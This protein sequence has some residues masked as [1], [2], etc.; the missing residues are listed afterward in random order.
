[1]K[2]SLQEVTSYYE[3]FE[4]SKLQ[5]LVHS[6]FKY[7]VRYSNL[8]AEWWL[9]DEEKRKEMDP[10]RTFAHNAFISSC[11]ALARNMQ[12]DKED[13]TWRV[14]MGEDRKDIGDFAILLVA[15]MGIKAR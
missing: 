14:K 8:R 13:V 15:V 10:E 3:I 7:A 2:I 5:P 1:M 9:A 12:I 11:N 6:M 4:S